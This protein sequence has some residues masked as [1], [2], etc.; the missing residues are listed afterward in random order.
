MTQI[1]DLDTYKWKSRL[2]FLFT[3]SAEDEHYKKQLEALNKQEPGLRDRDLIVFRVVGDKALQGTTPLAA[4]SADNLREKLEVDDTFTLIL[5]GKD[6]GVKRREEKNVAVD[7]LFAQIDS[8]P[9]RQRE[10]Q[11]D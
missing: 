7:E 8:M 9:M 11:H 4:G 1:V 6:G 10:M 3:P 2:L 5:M